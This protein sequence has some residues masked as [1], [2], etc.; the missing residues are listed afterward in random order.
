[1]ISVQDRYNID[2][3]MNQMVSTNLPPFLDEYFKI[4]DRLF[5]KVKLD[6]IP[7]YQTI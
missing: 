1:M 5:E 7:V 4:P 6:K 2:I 3:L